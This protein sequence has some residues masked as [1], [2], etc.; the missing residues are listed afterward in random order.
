MKEKWGV[1]IKHAQAH[2]Y[3]ESEKWSIE[4]RGI[5]RLAGHK[6]S[7]RA[8]I[9]VGLPHSWRKKTILSP[10]KWPVRHLRYGERLKKVL[11]TENVAIFFLIPLRLSGFLSMNTNYIQSTNNTT[12][13]QR[14]IYI[15]MTR[16]SYDKELLMYAYGNMES[17]NGW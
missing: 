8:R 9:K 17:E 16:W 10:W 15:C 7:Q 2:R 1:K 5:R 14:Y 3:W 13:T 12:M 6:V 11:P 4:N